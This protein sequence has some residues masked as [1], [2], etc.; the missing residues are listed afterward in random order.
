MTAL[1]PYEGSGGP[2][3][4]EG[5]VVAEMEAGAGGGA[6]DGEPASGADDEMP[7]QASGSSYRRS[8]PSGTE[9]GVSPHAAASSLRGGQPLEAGVRGRMES[10]F[11]HDFG[12]VRVHAGTTADAV[13]TSLHARAFTVG[14]RIGFS[15][16]R[17]RPGAP[18][19]VRLLAHELTHV[20]QQSSGL[21]GAVLRDGIG[22]PGDRYEVEAE[23]NADLLMSGAERAATAGK[24]VQARR[25]GAA[26]STT[27]DRHSAVQLYSGSSAAAYARSHALSSNPSYPRFSN[28]CTNFVSQAALAGGWT[29]VGGSCGD[30]KDN[31]VWWYGGGNCW[32][33][34]VRASYTWA[35]A[36]N[37]SRFAAASGRGTTAAQVRDLDIGDI[38]QMAFTGSH[39]GHSMVVTGKSSSDLLLSYHTSDH[40]DEPF[41]APGGILSRY[42]TA[43]YYAWKL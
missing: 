32:Y 37:F 11:G 29:M 18:E 15:A 17:Y 19:S 22:S 36:H 8:A 28:D 9:G 5:D 26:R 33:P 1:D 2:I 20:V 40:L 21:S 39:I 35:G 12:R 43:T 42:P 38:L 4:D 24:D 27:E 25:P 14:N 3:P 13:A 16:G 23:R 34:G 31:G 41:W 7:V 6:A 30:R 10:F